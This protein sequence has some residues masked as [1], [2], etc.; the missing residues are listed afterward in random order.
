MATSIVQSRPSR[1]ITPRE[2]Y[3]PSKSETQMKYKLNEKNALVKKIEAA[4]R[5][6]NVDIQ[7]KRG[8]LVMTFTPGAYELYKQAIYKFYDSS[9]TKTYS[10]TFKT[11]KTNNRSVEKAIVEESLSIKGKGN[12]YSDKR[13][14]FRINMFNTTSKMDVNGRLYQDFICSDLPEIL[15][16]VN[17]KEVKLVNDKILEICLTVLANQPKSTTKPSHMVNNNTNKDQSDELNNSTNSPL[18]IDNNSIMSMS[19]RNIL[20]SIGNPPKTIVYPEPRNRKDSIDNNICPICELAVTDSDS[21]E[22]NACDM[23]LH[24]Y[25][26]VLSDELFEKHTTD[27]DMLYTCHLCTLLD[28][29][30]CATAIQDECH[31]SLVYFDLE[32]DREGVMT[33]SVAQP[34]RNDVHEDS[35]E[36]MKRGRY[37]QIHHKDI[38]NF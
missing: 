20:M 27:I 17:L 31:R 34:I 33:P 4:E 37:K 8:T 32:T 11:S 2:L 1:K 23:W 35:I 30:E 9:N 16:T 36:I 3:T 10:K 26:T 14:H 24:K 12:V 7:L 13:Q 22:C 6:H 25:C 38:L 19:P 21:I 29:D 5:E 15:K 28:Q 18:T